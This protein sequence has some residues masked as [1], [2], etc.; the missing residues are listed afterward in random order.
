MR[1]STKKKNLFL[2]VALVALAVYIAASL[3][4]LKIRLDEDQQTLSSLQAQLQSG[5]AVLAQLKELNENKDQR[6]EQG[7]REQGMSKSGES[8]YYVVPPEE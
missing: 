1:V 6:L 4:G 2:R 5:N 3:I 8:V 7:A